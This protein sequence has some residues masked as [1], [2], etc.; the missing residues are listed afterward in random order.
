MVT[1]GPIYVLLEMQWT[2]N[3]LGFRYV[4]EK[5]SHVLQLQRDQ[6]ENLREIYS[7]TQH[8]NY[9]RSTIPTRA[10]NS[11]GCSLWH[12]FCPVSLTLDNAR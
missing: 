6:S 2:S 8:I 5:R 11:Y 12:V 4:C 10:I 9:Y 3:T 1:H 7:S